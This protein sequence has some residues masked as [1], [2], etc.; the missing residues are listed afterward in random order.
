[1]TAYLHRRGPSVFP[2]NIPKRLKKRKEKNSSI[3]NSKISPYPSPSRFSFLSFSFFF[4]SFL[5]FPSQGGRILFPPSEF[6]VFVSFI[7]AHFAS[8]RDRWKTR[9]NPT[10]LAASLNAK[11]KINSSYLLT[12][13][14]ATGD[15]GHTAHFHDCC[16]ILI[17]VDSNGKND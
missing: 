15:D 9:T 14:T 17:S 12:S 10:H 4:F 6:L 11:G 8:S 16:S 3:G 7:L 2:A 13:V 5:F 1:M